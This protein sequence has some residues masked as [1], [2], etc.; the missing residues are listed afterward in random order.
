M[1]ENSMKKNKLKSVVEL[2][3]ELWKNRSF[4]EI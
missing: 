1:Q 2:H 3:S 4:K